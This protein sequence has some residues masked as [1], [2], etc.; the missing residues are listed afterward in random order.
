[1]VED[2]DEHELDA[3]AIN[4][5]S[6]SSH[7]RYNLPVPTRGSLPPKDRNRHVEG[8]SHGRQV[9]PTVSVNNLASAASG[10][11]N[12]KSKHNKLSRLFNV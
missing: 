10:S 12:S 1:M 5:H 8:R 11:R 9:P 7:R 3:M 6:R 4:P 2:D